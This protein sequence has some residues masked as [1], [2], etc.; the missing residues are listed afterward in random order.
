MPSSETCASMQGSNRLLPNQQ[1]R[2]RLLQRLHKGRHIRLTEP[3]TA[4]WVMHT[5][6][7]SQRYSAQHTECSAELRGAVSHAN[8]S[9]LRNMCRGSAQPVYCCGRW[10]RQVHCMNAPVMPCDGRPAAWLCATRQ[11]ALCGV[12]MA[13]LHCG[14]QV[15]EVLFKLKPA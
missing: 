11:L 13:I 1:L 10:S 6:L 14:L 5:Y 7:L 12:A 3:S 4:R 8:W 15:L 2:R 9:L